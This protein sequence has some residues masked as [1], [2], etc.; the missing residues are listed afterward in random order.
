MP[1]YDMDEPDCQTKPNLFQIAQRLGKRQ[2][3]YNKKAWPWIG[4]ATVMECSKRGWKGTTGVV[5]QS[6]FYMR[7]EGISFYHH[8]HI[9]N[10]TE[11]KWASSASQLKKACIQNTLHTLW[12]RGLYCTT[13]AKASAQLERG[14]V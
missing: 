6:F 3:N 8:C 4:Q 2:V 1:V 12:Y 9:Q 11:Q 10:I 14:Q 13:F 7:P 5:N